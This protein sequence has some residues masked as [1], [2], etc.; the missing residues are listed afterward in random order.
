MRIILDRMSWIGWIG[1]RSGIV[2]FHY[3]ICNPQTV[4]VARERKLLRWLS[5]YMMWWTRTMLSWQLMEKEWW[6]D[7]F[8]YRVK[9]SLADFTN[10][11]TNLAHTR[12][13]PKE[14]GPKFGP[15]TEED[16]P[17]LAL[18]RSQQQHQPSWKN[19]STCYRIC[20][21]TLR[22]PDQSLLIFKGGKC[23]QWCGPWTKINILYHQKRSTFCSLNETLYYSLFPSSSCKIRY[24]SGEGFCRSFI[25]FHW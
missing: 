17:V 4:V 24:F 9:Q 10:G 11:S 20:V 5:L 2:E 6:Y 16:I 21:I 12:I 14:K 15:F 13:S 19:D 18:D 23:W 7:V 25:A 1:L 22:F 3:E 8:L